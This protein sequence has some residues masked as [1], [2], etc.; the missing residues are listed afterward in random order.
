MAWIDAFGFVK[1][2]VSEGTQLPFVYDVDVYRVVVFERPK[3][4][5]QRIILGEMRGNPTLNFA[6][7]GTCQYCGK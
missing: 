7:L 5:G 6:P 4:A 3:Q 1:K 2:E